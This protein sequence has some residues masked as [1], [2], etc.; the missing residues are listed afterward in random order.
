MQSNVLFSPILIG[1]GV[2]PS[3]ILAFVTG[4]WEIPPMGFPL[5]PT[6]TFISDET[7]IFPTASTCSLTLRLPLVLTSYDIFKEKVTTAFL[8]TVGFGQV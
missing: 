3:H 5:R 4:S 7:S 6:I 1:L 2:S 8:N